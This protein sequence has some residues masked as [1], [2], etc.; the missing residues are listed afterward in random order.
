MTAFPWSEEQ[1]CENNCSKSKW[2]EW[3]AQVTDAIDGM[4]A[5]FS[6]FPDMNVG[7]MA[8]CR[9]QELVTK[10]LARLAPAVY[11]LCLPVLTVL[12]TLL[13]CSIVVY[14]V[15]PLARISGLYYRKEAEALADKVLEV[16]K[17]KHPKAAWLS[18][19]RDGTSFSSQ[20]MSYFSTADRIPQSP[21][22][23]GW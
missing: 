5:L 10:E 6:I 21:R 1:I 20:L 18:I 7:F 9:Y 3:P 12:A 14:V 16:L 22:S 13:M 19:V 4:F 15:L 2:L 23:R 8:H 17:R 11:D